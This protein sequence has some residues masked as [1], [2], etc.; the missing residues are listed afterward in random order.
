MKKKNEL[1][2]VLSGGGARGIFDF[3]KTKEIYKF[4]YEYTKGMR[5]EILEKIL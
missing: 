2:I 3:K 1:G 4:A 5:E